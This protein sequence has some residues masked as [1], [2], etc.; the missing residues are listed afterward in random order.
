MINKNP[1]TSKPEATEPFLHARCPLES[2]CYF[3]FACLSNNGE[4][5]KGIQDRLSLDKGEIFMMN[6]EREE[7]TYT[8]ISGIASLMTY[9]PSGESMT[10]FLLEKSQTFGEFEVFFQ[11]K[12]FYAVQ[13]LSN[14]NICKLNKHHI[15][16][17]VEENP[18]FLF[19]V[20]SA[21]ENNIQAI[22]RH[23]WVMNAQ[24]VQ[25]RIMRLLSIF[26]TLNVS[27]WGKNMVNL[28]HEDLALLINT[29]RV[30]VTR[31]LNKLENEGFVKLG[32]NQIKVLKPLAMLDLEPNFR[33][34]P[35]HHNILSL[36][37]TTQT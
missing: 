27:E 9:L 28:S 19:K 23:I 25:E 31:V 10:V 13:A 17:F 2:N 3:S 16:Q 6:S 14:V 7:S 36:P 32:Y 37:V 18:T 22:G 5:N 1:P 4:R 29:D 20:I 24:R 21:V 15:I 35:L 33:L 26:N 34:N 12:P 30:S 11:K 8:I